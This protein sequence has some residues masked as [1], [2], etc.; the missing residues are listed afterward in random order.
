LGWHPISASVSLQTS[1]ETGAATAECGKKH[2]ALAYAG[3]FHI[4]A[5]PGALQLQ[6]LSGVSNCKI[7]VVVMLLTL[8]KITKQRFF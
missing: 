1:R 3:V 7:D 2:Q 8:L 4:R 5:T 6:G